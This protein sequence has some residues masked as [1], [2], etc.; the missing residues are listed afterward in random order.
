MVDML[1][2]TYIHT[3]IAFYINIQN[4]QNSAGRIGPRAGGCRPLMYW[5][6]WL[7][8]LPYILNVCLD[9]E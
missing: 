7:A 3:Y 6:V 1:E 9:S 2:H 5:L 4:I 8:R